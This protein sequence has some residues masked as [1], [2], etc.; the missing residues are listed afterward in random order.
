MTEEVEKVLGLFASNAESIESN[1]AQL[2]QQISELQENVIGT[3]KSEKTQ[4]IE[5]LKEEIRG[6]QEVV[7]EKDRQIRE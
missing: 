5:Q 2:R 7:R 4:D 6:L 3:I 1:F